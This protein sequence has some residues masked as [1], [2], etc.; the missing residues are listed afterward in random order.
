[1]PLQA[2]SSPSEP[3]RKPQENYMPVPLWLPGEM[4]FV[5][6]WAKIQ[7]ILSGSKPSA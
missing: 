4:C 6:R 7:H 3:P 1:M 2:D 5:G